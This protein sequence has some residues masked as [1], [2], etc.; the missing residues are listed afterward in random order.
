M[1]GGNIMFLKSILFLFVLGF[2]SLSMAQQVSPLSLK[3][4]ADIIVQLSEMKE[5]IFAGRNQVG[6]DLSQIF[7]GTSTYEKRISIISFS[8]TK[9]S[10][11]AKH[12]L[13]EIQVG[14]DDLTDDDTG[15][16]WVYGIKFILNIKKNS[17]IKAEYYGI[18][19]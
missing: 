2:F 13:C 15:Y 11:K 5:P 19:G 8:C 12:A 1:F 4:K 6:T 16:G 3:Q 9:N 10:P 14:Q 18:A 17:V 7:D